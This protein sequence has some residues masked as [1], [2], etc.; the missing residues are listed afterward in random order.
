MSVQDVN[1]LI[2]LLQLLAVAVAVVFIQHWHRR[3]QY[4][5]SQLAE[6]GED[7]WST[8]CR[9]CGRPMRDRP[10]VALRTAYPT[11]RGTDIVEHAAFHT[12]RAK[13]NAAAD[14]WGTS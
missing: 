11:G 5:A 8:R 7:R 2:S 12:D 9:C 4:L 6:K 10:C 14:Q 13:C 3:S 1:Q